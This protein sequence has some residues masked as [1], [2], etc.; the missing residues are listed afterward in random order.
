MQ[1]TYLDEICILKRL[2]NT[3]VVFGAD[4]LVLYADYLDQLSDF[5]YQQR[6]FKIP[7]ASHFVQIDQPDAFNRLIAGYLAEISGG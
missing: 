7:G 6:V 3:L 5:C 2:K 4:E 1:S